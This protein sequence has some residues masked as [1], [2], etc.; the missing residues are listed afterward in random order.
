MLSDA[1]TC[2]LDT[3]LNV[4]M[5]YLGYEFPPDCEHVERAVEMAAVL[6]ESSSHSMGLGLAEVAPHCAERISHLLGMRG[7]QREILPAPFEERL[8]RVR[9]V[10][11]AS[12]HRRGSAG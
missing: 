1:E 6:I 3:R 9:G 4:A 11:S 12:G 5:D 2:A 7:I 8:L 10:V